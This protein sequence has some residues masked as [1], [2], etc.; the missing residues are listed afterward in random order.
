MDCLLDWEPTAEQP[1][2]PDDALIWYDVPLTFEP[3]SHHPRFVMRRE[4]RVGDDGEVKLADKPAQN[5]P[6]GRPGHG[7]IMATRNTRRDGRRGL[8]R[9]ITFASFASLQ[10]RPCNISPTG[11]PGA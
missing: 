9:T 3:P 7:Q 11:G 8:T 2:A 4:L 5:D 6:P 10:P 1:E